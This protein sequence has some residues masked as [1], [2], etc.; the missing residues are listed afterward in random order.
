MRPTEPT[1]LDPWRLNGSPPSADGILLEGALGRGSAEHP[2]PPSSGRGHE[3]WR[4]ALDGTVRTEPPQRL[5]PG[6]ACGTA[7]EPRSLRRRLPRMGLDAL[8][9]HFYSTRAQRS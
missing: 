7:F 9:A 2:V 3:Q 5:A 6:E 8:Q 4:R 1:R